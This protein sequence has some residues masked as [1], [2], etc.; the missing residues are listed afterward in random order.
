MKTWLFKTM[1]T[2]ICCLTITSCATDE[3]PIEH[4][5]SAVPVQL[6]LS[7]SGTPTTRDVNNSNEELDYT[8]E[9]QNR[10]NN[11]Y[12]VLTDNNNK[13]V[14]VIENLT[15]TQQTSSKYTL[16]GKIEEYKSAKNIVVLVNIKDQGINTNSMTI[17]NW[18]KSFVGETIQNL[19]AATIYTNTDT[20]GW[21]ITSRAI[22]M[23]G[24]TTF[25]A[26]FSN[27]T[28]IASCDLQ[29]A[30][31]KVNIWVNEKKG[32]EG[33]QLDKIIVNNQLDK[34][35]CTSGNSEETYIP[36][37]AQTRTAIEYNCQS[38]TTAF[39]DLIYLPEQLNN[40]TKSVTLTVH[41][42][43]NGISKNNVIS[44]N[45]YQWD[46]IRN[47]SYIFNISAVTPTTIECK[48]YY[49]VEKWDE[50]PINLPNFN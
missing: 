23:W 12:I 16:Y 8:T 26:T 22:P 1:I 20:N 32:F 17:G 14:E 2:A 3:I 9:Q 10:I 36:T 27:G 37:N 5:E 21:D 47:H 18:L 15:I 38:A 46:I 19:Y 4:N 34:G 13:I 29:R 28:A 30:L 25:P 43:Y 44:F 49:V 39:S 7:F 31:A 6:T 35:Y 48:L 42:T 41:Y 45:D 24:T 50:V 11:A 40:D 33:F